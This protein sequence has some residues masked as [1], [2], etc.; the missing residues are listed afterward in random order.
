MRQS[1]FTIIAAS[2]AF[3]AFACGSTSNGGGGSTPTQETKQTLAFRGDCTATACSSPPSNLSTAPTV[4]CSG[5][6]ATDCQWTSTDADST[7]S[8]RECAAAECPA[9][10]DIAC[11]TGTA[12]ASQTCGSE[13]DAACTWTSSCVPPRDTTPCPQ[14]NGCDGQAMIELGIVC[15]DGSTGAFVCVTDGKACHLERNCD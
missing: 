6:T 9:K 2:F 8:Y 7:V 1:F 10:P 11:P 5:G 12:L 3:T 4:T 13:N 14:A 15:K